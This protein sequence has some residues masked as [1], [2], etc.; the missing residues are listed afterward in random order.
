MSPPSQDVEKYIGT[1]LVTSR[2]RRNNGKGKKPDPTGIGTECG[3]DKFLRRNRPNGRELWRTKSGDPIFVFFDNGT[4]KKDAGGSFLS[5]RTPLSKLA[6]H[7]RGPPLTI[8]GRCE[9]TRKN[10]NRANHGSGNI[11][12]SQSPIGKRPEK[13]NQD[14]SR[15]RGGGTSD[16]LSVASDE[17]SGSGHSENCLPR[18]IKPRKRRKKDRKPT[19]AEAE[20]PPVPTP[21]ETAS[22]ALPPQLTPEKKDL[23]TAGG[24]EDEFHGGPRL[25]HSFEEVTESDAV[26][27]SCSPSSCGCRYCDPSGIWDA[28]SSIP[29]NKNWTEPGSPSFPLRKRREAALPALFPCEPRWNLRRTEENPYWES[30]KGCEIDSEKEPSH[31][32]RVSTEIVTSPNGH[33]DIEIKFYSV[34]QVPRRTVPIQ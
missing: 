25:D 18:I 6:A 23:E 33:R 34:S 4:K 24:S 28:P 30:L 14:S 31:G 29:R 16:R 13:S 12:V 10:R 1:N 2:S 20:E 3:T 9:D 11:G 17:S 15:G 27:Y 19:A 8:T 26:S 22:P 21:C 32:L 7:A 5:T